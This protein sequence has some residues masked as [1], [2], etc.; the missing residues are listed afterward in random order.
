V[1]LNNEDESV[2]TPCTVH[3]NDMKTV[4]TLTE[5]IL[6]ELRMPQQSDCTLFSLTGLQLTDDDLWFLQSQDHLYLE[7]QNRPFDMRQQIDQYQME[8]LIGEG[9]FGKVYKAFHKK[10][11]DVVAVKIIDISESFLS[12]DKVKEIYKE[13]SILQSL[14]HRNIIKI[15]NAFVIR[16]SLYLIMEYAG[17]G[18]VFDFV[19]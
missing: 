17:G 3:T 14:S 2:F 4:V 1:R 12:A 19:L 11:K 9:S 5:V 18:E 6:D 16:K 8:S 15:H 13:A 7:T 10:T